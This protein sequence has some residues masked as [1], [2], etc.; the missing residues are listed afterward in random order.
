MAGARQPRRCDCKDDEM[1]L[2]MDCVLID[3]VD[4]DAMSAFWRQTLGIERVRTGPLTDNATSSACA[5]RTQHR[6]LLT[7]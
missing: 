7:A 4:L 1:P 5:R 6:R 3:S 2:V